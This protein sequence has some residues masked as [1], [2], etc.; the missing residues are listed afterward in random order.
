MLLLLEVMDDPYY[1]ALR[2]EDFGKWSMEEVM[3]FGDRE[4]GMEQRTPAKEQGV[5]QQ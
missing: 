5:S 1:M 3:Q 4:P 2:S